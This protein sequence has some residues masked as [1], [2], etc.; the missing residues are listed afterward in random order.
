VP[1]TRRRRRDQP[2]PEF[3]I[4]RSLG[5]YKVPEQLRALGF[6]VYAI[7]DVYPDTEESE[8]DPDWISEQTRLG[9][10]LICRDKLRHPGERDAVMQNSARMFRVGNSARNGTEQG[11]YLANNIHRIVQRSQKPGPYIYRV[12]R[13]RIV[14]VFP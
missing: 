5:R 13:D 12:D 8:R 11:E 14:K 10:V 3:F 6:V 1:S 4:D 2:P 9:R 7:F